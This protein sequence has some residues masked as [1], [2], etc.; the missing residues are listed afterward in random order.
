MFKILLIQNLN[1]MRNYSYAD[2]RNTILGFGFDVEL[3]T[4][5][6]ID[7]IPVA[8]ADGTADCILFA[9]NSLNDKVIREYVCSEGFREAFHRFV[10]EGKACLILHQNSVTT[11][12]GITEPFPFI[13]ET[14]TCCLNSLFHKPDEVELSFQDCF[15]QQYFAFP[16][17]VSFQDIQDQSSHAHLLGLYWTTMALSNNDFWVPV[18]KDSKGENLMVKA[19]KHKILY[20]SLLLDWQEHSQLLNNVLINL[21]VDN[22]SLAILECAESDSLGY[23]YFLHS[24]RSSKLHYLKYDIDRPDYAFGYNTLVKNIG[25]GLHSTLLVTSNAK[26]KLSSQAYEQFKR[27]GVKI[28]EMQE[29][30]E[31]NKDSFVIHSAEKSIKCYLNET[32]LKIQQMLVGGFINNSFIKTIDVLMVLMDFQKIGITKG[33]YNQDNLKRITKL[34]ADRIDSNGSF[35]NTFGATCKA[36]WYFRTFY[37]AEDKT[38]RRIWDYIQENHPENI[39]LIRESLNY[40]TACHLMGQSEQLLIQEDTKLIQEEHFQIFVTENGLKN[41]PLQFNEYDVLAV[42]K[43]GQMTKNPIVLQNILE[44]IR[45]NMSGGQILNSQLTAA[46]A[47]NFI[48]YYRHIQNSIKLSDQEKTVLLGQIQSVLFEMIARLKH[49]LG[50]LIETDTDN[51]F[52]DVQLYVIRTLY[53]FE[54]IVS[55]PITDL[56]DLV[57]TSGNY[58]Q[59]MLELQNSIDKVQDSRIETEKYREDIKQYKKYKPFEKLFYVFLGLS[60][61]LLYV[62]ITLLLEVLR[63]SETGDRVKELLFESWPAAFSAIVVPVIVKIYHKIRGKKQS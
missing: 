9:S 29:E 19:L 17:S 21:I 34:I 2:C 55:F 38:T 36:L 53:E 60:I 39:G 35:D 59:L 37:G 4:M 32:E 46:Y 47:H 16:H 12:Y 63:Y 30:A 56:I 52:V 15:Y 20:S 33:S 61:A 18:L 1:E 43:I 40:L 8:M 6:N 7:R 58:P 22:N 25:L 41:S 57:Y 62:T 10:D 49:D 51:K 54:T 48:G 44:Y 28:I 31:V 50:H 45:R 27:Q 3:Y 26:G 42:F 14:S 24:L 13:E 5:E 11:K 23:N